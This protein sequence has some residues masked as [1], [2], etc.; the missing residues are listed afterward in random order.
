[1]NK[2]EQGLTAAVL[3]GELPMG[4]KLA[5]HGRW[6]SPDFTV[7]VLLIVGPQVLPKPLKN[8]F[9]I[10]TVVNIVASRHSLLP[11]ITNEVHRT[12]RTIYFLPPGID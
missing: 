1:M 7:G 4:Q 6:P 9:R 11:Y 5:G 10:S 2:E 8:P 3:Q 12:C